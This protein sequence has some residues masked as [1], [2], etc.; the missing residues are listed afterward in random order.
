MLLS[1]C[2]LRKIE[3][4]FGDKIYTFYY[5]LYLIILYATYGTRHV[6]L[7]KAN[8]LNFTLNCTKEDI[9]ANSKYQSFKKFHISYPNV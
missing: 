5:M 7:F 9:N 3:K 8:F 4:F 6:V 1:D 2:K